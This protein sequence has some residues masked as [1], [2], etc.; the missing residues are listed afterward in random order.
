MQRADA[1]QYEYPASADE[2]HGDEDL[3]VT[4][5]LAEDP[6]DSDWGID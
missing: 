5:D 6:S 1:H 4:E 3:Q 2:G